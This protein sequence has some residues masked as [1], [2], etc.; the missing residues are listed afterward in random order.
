MGQFVRRMSGT[1]HHS[2]AAVRSPRPRRHSSACSAVVI[3]GAD[4]GAADGGAAGG[5]SSPPSPAPAAPSPEGLAAAGAAAAAAPS[6]AYRST[7]AAAGPVPPGCGAG[8]GSSAM[9]DGQRARVVS[10][11]SL[12]ET[13]STATPRSRARRPVR[14]ASR[15]E[16]AP[17]IARG[18]VAPRAT[19]RRGK[20]QVSSLDVLG[21]V[22]ERAHPFGRRQ[23]EQRPNRRVSH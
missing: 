8:G 18:L 17:V 23:S 21:R 3:D 4:G 9:P 22:G 11:L 14:R 20:R 6:A 15:R 16:R 10:D 5:L 7:A 2:P 12:R 1:T 13:R 19:T